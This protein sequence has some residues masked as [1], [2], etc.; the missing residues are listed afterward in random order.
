VKLTCIFILLISV[1]CVKDKNFSNGV[2]WDKLQAFEL[3]AGSF[4]PSISQEFLYCLFVHPNTLFSI[5]S[6]LTV[7]GN[8]LEYFDLLLKIAG[9]TNANA[10]AAITPISCDSKMPH[11]KLRKFVS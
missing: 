3:S 1:S 6:D 5:I 11:N 10:D 9:V 7:G 8:E 2:D 4:N